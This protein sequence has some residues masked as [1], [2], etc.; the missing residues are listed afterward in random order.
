MLLALAG[1]LDANLSRLPHNVL[2]IFQPSEETTGGAKDLCQS[3]VLEHFRVRKIFGLHL[4]PGLEPGTVWS[5]PGPLMARSN[6][7]DVTIEG[8]SVHLSRS[9]DG[10]DALT[11]GVTYLQRAYSM[12]SSRWLSLSVRRVTGIPVQPATTEAMS[13]AVTGR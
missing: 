5:R 11:A 10:L 9:S 6:E 3:N 13:S 12:C 4:W 7:V 8:K 2:L 1:F